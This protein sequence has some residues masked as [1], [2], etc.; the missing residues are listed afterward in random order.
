LSFP[1]NK[2]TLALP[3]ETLLQN[4]TAIGNDLES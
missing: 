1:V 3:L 2:V 4:I